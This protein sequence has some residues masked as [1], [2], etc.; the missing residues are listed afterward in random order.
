MG[1]PVTFETFDKED[2]QDWEVLRDM[3]WETIASRVY[4]RETKILNSNICCEC[5]NDIT[6]DP[7]RKCY[8]YNK[9]VGHVLY[10]CRQSC[11]NIFNSV[12]KVQAYWK[13]TRM[14]PRRFGML[15]Q[16]SRSG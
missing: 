8:Y 12:C 2:S 16:S 6:I 5:G 4:V 1:T 14:S 3:T 9:W 13:L 11:L 7:S 15:E 10:F